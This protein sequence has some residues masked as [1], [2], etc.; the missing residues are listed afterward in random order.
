MGSDR[1]S[2]LWWPP[3]YGVARLLSGPV[4][5]VPLVRPGPPWQ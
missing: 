5:S 2:V 4:P 3:L 1:L